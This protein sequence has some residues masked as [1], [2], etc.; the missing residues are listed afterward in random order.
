MRVETTDLNEIDVV[1]IEVGDLVTLTFDAIPGQ[2][3]SGTVS[4][5]SPKAT[6]GLGVNYTVII[7]LDDIPDDARWGMTVFVDINVGN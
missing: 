6:E 4:Q 5:I 7:E 3:F 1:Q 2:E